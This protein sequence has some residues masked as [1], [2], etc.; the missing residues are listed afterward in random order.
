VLA[1][2][3]DM[4]MAKTQDYVRQI[5][6]TGT[7][8][9]RYLAATPL[10]TPVDFEARLISL[11]R[12]KLLCEGSVWVNGEQTVSAEGIWISAHGEYALKPEF[13]SALPSDTGV[14]S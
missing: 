11:E 13:V 8:N 1:L 3:L 10:N 4:L 9:I 2:A 7:L 6:M 12:R 5:G 14:A